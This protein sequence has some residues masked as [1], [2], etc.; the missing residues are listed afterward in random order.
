M[1]PAGI[2]C[3]AGRANEDR[4]GAA[5]SAIVRRH[6]PTLLPARQRFRRRTSCLNIQAGDRTA[7]EEMVFPARMLQRCPTLG[8]DTD[9][10]RSWG[11]GPI[12]SYYSL[13]GLP[14]EGAWWVYGCSAPP[15]RTATWG[16]KPGLPIDAA[17]YRGLPLCSG[18]VDIPPTAR[19]HGHSRPPTSCG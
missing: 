7:V 10:G 9:Q 8:F 13:N 14:V 12:S 5:R 2:Q 17:E 19:P 18:S 3:I 15:A 16:A 6:E 4:R 11:A 1:L